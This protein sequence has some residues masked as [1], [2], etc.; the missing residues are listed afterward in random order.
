MSTVTPGA[1]HEAQNK[2]Q[3]T[4]HE[5]VRPTC[6]CLLHDRLRLSLWRRRAV[7]AGSKARDRHALPGPTNRRSPTLHAI[8]WDAGL[9]AAR[10]RCDA[11]MLRGGPRGQALLMP[12]ARGSL[13]Q[14]R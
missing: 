4:K 11:A 2:Q 7:G 12:E 10:G 8:H 13:R 3:H 1:L 9:G 5:S 14:P 6:S